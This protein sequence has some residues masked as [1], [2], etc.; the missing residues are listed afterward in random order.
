[1]KVYKKYLKVFINKIYCGLIN[2]IVKFNM[3]L[4]IYYGIYMLSLVLGILVFLLGLLYSG[5]V[6][7]CDSFDN[8][9]IRAVEGDSPFPSDDGENRVVN[10]FDDRVINELHSRPI[11]YQPYHPGLQSTNQGYRFELNGSSRRLPAE[12]DS[13]SNSI[14]RPNRIY[15]PSAYNNQD[16]RPR[17]RVVVDDYYGVPNN[18][19]IRNSRISNTGGRVDINPIDSEFYRERYATNPLHDATYHAAGESIYKKAKHSVNKFVD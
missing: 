5:N 19:S 9:F 7:Y 4:N 14:S 17:A 3:Y 10:E 13:G 6:I 12:L 8:D 15:G 18:E 1:M 16:L 2:V 11:I